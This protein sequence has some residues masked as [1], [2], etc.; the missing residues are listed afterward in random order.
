MN[1]FTPY[2]KVSDIQTAVLEPQGN[3]SV[4]PKAE[5]KPVTLK[6]MNIISENK[7]IT[8]PLILDGRIIQDNLRHVGKTELWLL[9]ELKKQGINRYE[10]EAALVELDPSWNV[11]VM[12]K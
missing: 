7:P 3:I 4:F 10:K 6:D 2:D 12:R 8:L 1:F 9:A 5:N 11:V